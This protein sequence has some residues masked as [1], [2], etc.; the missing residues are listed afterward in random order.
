MLIYNT[1]RT[2]R[3]IECFIYIAK[4]LKLPRIYLLIEAILFCYS[5]NAYK[6]YTRN[7]KRIKL[8][9]DILT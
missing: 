1:F 2:N 7:I 3:P 8:T 4:N 9:T 6:K 5:T